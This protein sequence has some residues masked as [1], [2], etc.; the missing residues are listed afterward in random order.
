MCIFWTLLFSSFV[1]LLSGLIVF[2]LQVV[3]SSQTMLLFR[4]AVFCPAPTGDSVTRKS[5][6]DSLVAGCIPV[7]FSRASLSQYMWFVSEKE[8]KLL[9]NLRRLG[10]NFRNV[11]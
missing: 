4:T 1:F 11:N 7:L 9:W 3:D 5:V 10:N 6:F 8:V 2:A